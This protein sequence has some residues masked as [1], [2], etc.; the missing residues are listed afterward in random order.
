MMKRLGLPLPGLLS[1]C[2]RRSES[3]GLTR[4]T[5]A[6]CHAHGFAA[7]TLGADFQARSLRFVRCDSQGRFRS[8]RRGY[9]VARPGREVRNE[10]VGDLSRSRRT[11]FRWVLRCVQ[12]PGFRT[13]GAGQGSQDFAPKVPGRVAQGKL[14]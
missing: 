10:L 12:P 8:H 1:G 13:E 3:A 14:A 5:I 6:E 7:R 11:L 2:R 9:P 4:R